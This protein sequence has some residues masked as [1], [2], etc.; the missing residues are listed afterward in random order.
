VRTGG[1]KKKRDLF[2][3]QDALALCRVVD[4]D[5]HDA[6]ISEVRIA[7]EIPAE[8]RQEAA[9]AARTVSNQANLACSRTRN[10][11][12]S[13][14]AVLVSGGVRSKLSALLPAQRL[15][16]ANNGKLAAGSSHGY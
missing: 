14:E 8:T 5:V 2:R 4:L 16:V 13:H 10:P 7:F 15:G 1:C 6:R 11:A 12:S 3:L 9:S